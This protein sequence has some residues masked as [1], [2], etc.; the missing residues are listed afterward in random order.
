M[1]VHE[2]RVFDAAGGEWRGRVAF[3]DTRDGRETPEEIAQALLDLVRDP[4]STPTEVLAGLG[5]PVVLFEDAEDGARVRRR[6]NSPANAP[7][8]AGI[9]RNLPEPAD[10]REP[11]QK[12][13][14]PL[15]EFLDTY[16]LP[17]V[18]PFPVKLVVYF[19]LAGIPVP[20]LW[21]IALPHTVAVVLLLA[22]IELAIVFGGLF[23]IF[24]SE[25]LTRLPRGEPVQAPST[26]GLDPPPP[27]Q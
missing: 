20:V 23:R 24:L 27:Q 25:E 12:V 5:E 11:G 16:H 26:K 9:H 7:R 1:V 17:R 6:G 3:R 14:G 2:L 13:E 21:W 4:E 15:E 22:V 18:V 10:G 19:V 8:S